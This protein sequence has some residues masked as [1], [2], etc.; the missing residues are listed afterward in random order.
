MF[1]VRFSP[2]SRLVTACYEDGHVGFCDVATGNLLKYI[3]CH[4]AAVKSLRFTPDGLGFVTGSRD[5]T[6]KY[7]LLSSILGKSSGK[8]KDTQHSDDETARVAQCAREFLGHEDNVRA[9]AVHAGRWIASGSKD[10]EVRFWD[11]TTG[12]LQCTLQGH[13]YRKCIHLFLIIRL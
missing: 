11:L 2:D 9:V 13:N 10:G 3:K 7:W 1:C 12:E 6:V 4:E 8:S 5:Q